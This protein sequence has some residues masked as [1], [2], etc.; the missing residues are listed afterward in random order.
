MT[1]APKTARANL[2][3][4][5]GLTAVVVAIAWVVDGPL[6]AAIVGGWLGAFVAILHFGRKRSEAIKIMGGMGDE[7]I[8][9]L[10]TRALAFAGGIMAFALPATW[11]ASVLAGEENYAVGALSAVFAT[12]FI[13]ASIVLE[14]RG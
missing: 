9:A 6:T 14:Q 10:S 8:R 13:G 4:M 12:A 7:R 2:I 3:W 1:F 11:L 5:L